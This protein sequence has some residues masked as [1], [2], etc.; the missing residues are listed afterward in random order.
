MW[1]GVVPDP[2]PVLVLVLVLVLR[3]KQRGIT[4]L[5]RCLTCRG[6]SIP[7]PKQRRAAAVPWKCTGTSYCLCLRTPLVTRRGEAK[8]SVTDSRHCSCAAASPS[9]TRRRHTTQPAS[10]IRSSL[11]PALAALP[12]KCLVSR[13][14]NLFS[15]AALRDG[16]SRRRSRSRSRSRS[17]TNQSL[18]PVY[19]S[20][21]HSVSVSVSVSVCPSHRLR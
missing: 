20:A 13:A 8:R 16:R 5:L 12:G 3:S 4:T 18:P 19:L 17:R 21:G 11:L 2:V 6:S 14:L 15:A 9:V 7:R 1:R 10:S